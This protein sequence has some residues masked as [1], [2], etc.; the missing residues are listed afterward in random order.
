MHK[1][2]LVQRAHRKEERNEGTKKKDCGVV[3]GYAKDLMWFSFL[4]S[5]RFLPQQKKKRKRLKVS[6]VGERNREAE[7]PERW[8][9]RFPKAF[10]FL[11]S[12][13]SLSLSLSILL[14]SRLLKISH[15][16]KTMPAQ[17]QD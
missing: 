15:H 16:S 9:G 14:S 13:L 1:P 17:V 11:S 10:H 2:R 8:G 7:V 4:A 3:E 6:E 5:V 12:F